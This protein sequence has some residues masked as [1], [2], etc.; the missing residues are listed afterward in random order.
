MEFVVHVRRVIE[1]EIM[2][3]KRGMEECDT[4]K[5]DCKVLGVVSRIP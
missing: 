3:E 4:T 1:T 2:E 5:W